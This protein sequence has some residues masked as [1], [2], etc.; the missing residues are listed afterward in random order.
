[1][2][3]DVQIA[4]ARNLLAIVKDKSALFVADISGDELWELYQN[5]F[6]EGTNPV[7]RTRREH[8]CG[9]CK[10]FVRAVGNLV[11]IEDNAIRSIWN[12]KVADAAFQQVFDSM[13]SAVEGAGIKDRF[14]T[15]IAKFGV[16]SNYEK[17]DDNNVRTWNHFFAV[18]PKAFVDTSSRSV[19]ELTGEYREQRNVFKRSITE[20]S[21]SAVEE[22]LDLISQN[23]LYKGE[24][25]KPVLEKFLALQKECLELPESQREVFFWDRPLSVGAAVSKIRNHSIGTL[26]IDLSKGVDINAA[27]KMYEKVV[28]PANYKRPK[29]V[30]SERQREEAKKKV[31]ELGYGDS[32]SR[33]FAT[34][35]DLTINNVLFR[36]RPIITEV[37]ILG[38]LKAT[39]N[40]NPGS[41]DRVEEVSI[42]KFV[43]DVLPRTVKVEVF[44]E[45][46]HRANLV[47]LISPSVVGSKSILKWGNG[48]SWAYNGNITDSDITQRV[49]SAGGRTDGAFRFSHSWN[50]PDT[51]NASLMDLHV[52]L[53]G[54]S[55]VSDAARKSGIHD[56]YGNDER[57]GWNRRQ[58][59][60][61][62]GVQDVD[63]V[64]PAPEGY[65][66][67][68]NITFPDIHRMPPGVYG[69]AIHNWRF[70][71]PTLGGFKAEIAFGGQVYS[72]VRKE[73]MKN[74]EWVSVA[75]VRLQNG[76]F[77][78][79]EAM[80]GSTTPVVEW[81]LSMG[82]F[83]NVSVCMFSP[84]YWDGQEGIGNKHYFFMVDGCINKTR[85]NGFYNE[86]LDNELMKQKSVFE[87]LGG[88]MQV[89]DSDNQLSGLG[90]SS[91]QRNS[92]VC[93]V[94]G[95]TSRIIRVMF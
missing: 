28:A 61:T 69:C 46:S 54:H 47:S 41:F 63:Y 94:T 68:E 80:P 43:S 72:F 12:V 1:M 40:R 38:G 58:H 19:P 52:F 62:G 22:V 21:G 84:N 53:P 16:E 36:S 2:F 56:E 26:L 86:F 5:S 78:M 35:D 60:R 89:E 77:E 57:V 85:P 39:Q 34:L 33:R 20:L 45:N 13:S 51:R 75:T 23:S 3:H 25:W 17:I 65:I 50:Y 95:H 31:I 59:A 14:Y 71:A 87:A 73:P 79:V 83:H 64:H 48:F 66:P 4:L 67:V 8:D 10:G 6:P 91:T 82:Q 42:E 74:K 29:P 92:I 24:E 76:R 88:V 11:V 30:F 55:G 32:L 18:L 9:S 44:V 90:F 7:F 81:G 37:D 93:R 15:K 27:V 49:Q 70:R